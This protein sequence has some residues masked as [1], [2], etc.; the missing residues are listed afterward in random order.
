MIQVISVNAK[1]LTIFHGMYR[2]KGWLP[3]EVAFYCRDEI[4]F[5]HEPTGCLLP[6]LVEMIAPEEA[7]LQVVHVIAGLS[8]FQQVI[9]FAQV[10]S[11][12]YREKVIDKG[13]AQ[14]KEGGKFFYNFF[15]G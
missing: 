13:F 3:G 5:A 9:I 15:H 12:D 11:F 6:F 4:A 10:E 8:I 7:L 1:Q 14:R 2:L